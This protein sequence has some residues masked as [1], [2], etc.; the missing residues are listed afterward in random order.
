MK[1]RSLETPVRNP[2]PGFQAGFLAHPGFLSILLFSAGCQETQGT[3]AGA[4]SWKGRPTPKPSEAPKKPQ[5][6]NRALRFFWPIHGR[7]RLG[8]SCVWP[9]SPLNSKKPRVPWPER[10]LGTRSPSSNTAGRQETQG[11]LEKRRGF[12]RPRPHCSPGAARNGCA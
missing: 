6:G 8:V 2:A 1:T 12:L 10:F 7:P 11:T 5:G 3:L 9:R 4:V